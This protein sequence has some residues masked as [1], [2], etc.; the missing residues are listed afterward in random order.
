MNQSSYGLGAGFTGM[1]DSLLVAKDIAA[2]ILK[3]FNKHFRIYREITREARYLFIRGDW[4]AERQSV[5]ERIS[6]VI[7]ASV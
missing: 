1:L 7:A 3:G 2:T 4:A 5:N 6:L